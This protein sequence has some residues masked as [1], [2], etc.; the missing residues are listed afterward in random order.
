MRVAVVMTTYQ[1]ARW[2]T[3]QARSIANQ[4]HPVDLVRVADDGSTDGT[5]ELLRAVLPAAEVSVNERR[6]GTVRSF[7][8]ILRDL[9]ADVVL[10]ADQDDR[11]HPERVA[12]LVETRG[13]TFHD[14]RLVDAQGEAIGESLWSRVGFTPA[15]RAQLALDPLGV[16]LHG[17][18]V[19]GAT[20]A[21]HRDVLALGLPLPEYGWHD[22]WLALV[23]AAHGCPVVALSEPLLDYRL[24]DANTAGLPPRGARARLGDGGAARQQRA[25]VIAMLGELVERLPPGPAVSRVASARAHLQRRQVLPRPRWRRLPGVA[26]LLVSGSYAAHGG[27]W[28]TAVV[29]V[30]EPRRD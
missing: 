13:L 10:L 12:R 19:T 5:L 2:V 29:D 20:V 3:E 16:L 21:V 8:G 22:Y 7:D 14:A 27:G 25:T 24:H 9:H 17:N 1:G 18:P 23:A 6:L 26:R 11:W 15:R 30:L 4:T 28:R